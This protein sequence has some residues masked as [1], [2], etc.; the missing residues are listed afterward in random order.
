MRESTHDTRN[1]VETDET[2][3]AQRVVDDGAEAV[4]DKH[5]QRDMQKHVV[6]EGRSEKGPIATVFEMCPTDEKVFGHETGRNAH[7]FAIIPEQVNN[8]VQSN[9]GRDQ[10][11][12]ISIHRERSL[13]RISRPRTTEPRR[14]SLCVSDV[15]QS[16]K[17]GDRTGGMVADT[18]A[19]KLDR[20]DD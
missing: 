20:S 4:E 18:D 15:A 10:D 12:W 9:Q 19:R 14:F 6:R 1:Q 3:R 8:D 5:V 11:L 7:F 2:F 17:C 16:V 13:V